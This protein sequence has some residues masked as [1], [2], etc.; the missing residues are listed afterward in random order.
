MADLAT[1]LV[2][3]TLSAVIAHNKVTWQS[4]YVLQRFINTIVRVFKR[5]MA[6]LSSLFIRSQFLVMNA[7]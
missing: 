3:I 6:L 5:V 1:H 7:V 4:L 2:G